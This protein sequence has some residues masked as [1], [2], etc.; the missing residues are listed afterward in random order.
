MGGRLAHFAKNWEEISNDPWILE[1]IRGY[2]VEFH[3]I[4]QQVGYP[5]E[6]QLDAT[7][8]QALTKE[9]EELVRKEAIVSPP[10]NDVGF[11]SQM[12]LAPKS[13]GSW[14]PVINLKS[15]N[16]YVIARHFK[17]ESIRTAKGLMQTGDWLVK[18]DLK[19]A[20]FSVPIHPSSQ[21]FLK[22]KWRGQTWQFKALPFGLSSAPYVFTKLMKPVVS[23]LRRLGIRSI[24]YLDD[25]L[26]MS[27][28]KEEARRHLATAVELLIALGFIINL[29]KSVLSP[30]QEL[31]FLGFVL[32]SLK[33]TI[34]L[35]SH[36]L[37]SLRRL[38]KQM[39]SQERTTV[40]EL[41]RILG[42]MIA[43]HPAILP[44]P[45][46][47]RNLEVA[48]TKALKEGC[49]YDSQVSVNS[50]MRLDLTWWVDNA[51]HHNGRPL[52]ITHWDCTIESDASTVGWGASCQG[53]NTGGPWTPQEKSFHINYL[54]L[55][56]AFLA[57]KSFARQE[58]SISILLRLDNVTAIA[59]LNRMGGTHSQSLSRLAV[60]IWDWC[61]ERN[62]TIHAEHLP[63]KQNVRADWESRHMTDS[64][65]W[66]LHRDIFLQ[67]QESFGPFTVDLFASRTNTQLPTYCSWK[68]DPAAPTVDALSISWENHHPYMF[69]PFAL[70]SRCLNKLR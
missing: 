34:S 32:N 49:S 52:Q 39:R 31:E 58:T 57:L 10:Y 65:D 6:I 53:R 47:Y 42:T 7:Q 27:R 25:M 26:I 54:K 69:P 21:K 12:F 40:Q 11:M 48:K 63:G 43:A 16:K 38:A 9:V 68:P 1:T 61:I 24:L 4:P 14:C 62:I 67:L 35:P 17:M 5:N 41:A 19:D 29:K 30:T 70:I 50:D 64:S 23:I 44:A 13:D 33:M 22:F 8:S 51:N 60:Q 3:T 15:L 28:S 66:Q 56:A 45:L 2:Q 20:Y 36:K 59:F 55:L 18:L 37:H 46:H